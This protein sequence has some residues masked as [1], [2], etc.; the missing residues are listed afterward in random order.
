MVPCPW[1]E[2][3]AAWA[4]ERPELDVGLHLTLTSEWRHYRWGPVSPRAEVPGLLDED[5]YLHRSVI[6]VAL[7]ATAAEVEKEIRAQVERAL[8]RGLRP[9][10]LDT[11]MGTLYARPDFTRVYLKVAAEYGI[12]AMA[13]ELTP[14]KLARFRGQGYPLTDEVVRLSREY[15]LPKLDD[16]RTVPE[17]KTYEEVRSKLLDLVRELE[18]G[19]TEV[20]F[21][22]SIET[23]GL[24]RITGSWRQRSWEA[25]LFSDPEV[26]AFL[27]KEGV[28]FTD[29]R[30]MM[31]RHAAKKESGED[32]GDVDPNPATPTGERP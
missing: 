5:G 11:H 2:E 7:R 20:I 10:H 21:H 9:G 4:R 13:I 28:L 27:A 25:R 29:W 15:P 17:G 30:E 3:I 32:E 24:R 18:P 12:P 16:L 14:E 26:K 23:D 19:I 31:R 1:F 6:Q 8:A 22:P